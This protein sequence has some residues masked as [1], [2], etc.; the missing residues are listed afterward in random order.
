[1]ERLLDV[2][3]KLF[4]VLL[5]APFLVA[6]YKALPFEPQL[7][8]LALSE[9]LAVF[10][11]LIHRRGVVRQRPSAWI[12]GLLG[13][14][15]P[16]LVRPDPSATMIA[17]PAV[18]TALMMAGLLLT[19]AAKLFLNR[20]FGIVAANRGI[21]RAGPY[22]LVRH[23]MYLGY[24]VGEIGF[25]LTSFSLLTLGLYLLAWGLQVGRILQEEQLLRED[26]DYRRYAGRVRWR[27]VPGLF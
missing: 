4:L 17:P 19:I 12:L 23:P 2:C 8:L 5:A 16:L 27:L 24:V 21:K 7:V 22:R 14:A 20:S 26:P 25:L 18:G 1:M 13:T 9:T 6:F 15:L 11:I 3:E 10:F